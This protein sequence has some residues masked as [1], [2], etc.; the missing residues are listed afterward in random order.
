[1]IDAP[2]YAPG[3]ERFDYVDPDAPKGGLVRF[4]DTGTFDSLNFVPPRG[5]TPL[6]LGMIYDTLM[7]S[8]MDEVSTM[9]GLLA[10]ALRFPPDYSSVTYRLREDARWHDGEPV[11]AEDVVFSFEMLKEHNP[12]QAFYYRHVTGADASGEREFTFT[13]DE[14]GNRELPHIVGQLMILPNH[15]WEGTDAAG[16]KRDIAAGTLEPPLGSG[17]YRVKSVSPGRTIAYERVDDYWGKDLP[18]NVGSNNFGEIRYEYF[19][20]ETVELQAFKA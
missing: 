19:R 14:Q 11:T 1:L 18:V 17:P 15:F 7:T 12:G 8:S 13:F 16:R 9:Y 10:E 6:G 3:F 5:S 2:K 4:A 20:D